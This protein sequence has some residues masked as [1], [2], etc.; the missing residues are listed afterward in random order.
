MPGYGVPES[1]ISDGNLANF[2]WDGSKVHLVDFELSGRSDRPFELAELV[3]QISMW[4]DRDVDTTFLLS[5][6]KL[7]DYENWR[8]REFRILFAFTWL[9]MLLPR[10]SANVKNPPGTLERQARRFLKFFD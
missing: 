4:V 1:L 3:E 8:L 7:T 6:F 9:L 5:R 2:L 10:R